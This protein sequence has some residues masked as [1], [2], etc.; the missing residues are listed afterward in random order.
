MQPPSALFTA[1]G[2]AKSRTAVAFDATASHV[3]GAVIASYLWAFGD[4]GSARGPLVSH[5]YSHPGT[6]AVRLTVTSNAGLSSTVTHTIRV[7]DRPPT[8]RIS[9]SRAGPLG[10]RMFA[11][12]ARAGDADGRVV[13]YRWSFGDGHYASGRAVHHTYTRR[14]SYRVTLTVR[15]NS[16]VSVTRLARLSVR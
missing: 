16:R 11:F 12:A 13:S 4:G 5:A 7:L 3:T 10:A 6:Y 8:A 1:D 2:K 9:L 14:G 15:D